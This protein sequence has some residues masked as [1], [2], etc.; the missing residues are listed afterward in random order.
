MT[1]CC[2]CNGNG[3]CRGCICAKNSRV[4][5]N[6]KPGKDKRCENQRTVPP[7]DGY[8]TAANEPSLNQHYVPVNE[9]MST[10]AF[11]TDNSASESQSLPDFVVVQPATF[12]WGEIEG[13]AF[14][15]DI[16]ESYNQIVH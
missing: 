4:C 3:W 7:P 10:T 5:T 14:R 15:Q 13:E 2:R 6:C 16:K 9:R 8:P 11:E 12:K 1:Q